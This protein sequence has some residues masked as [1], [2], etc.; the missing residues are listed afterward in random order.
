MNK[1]NM[2]VYEQVR[3]VPQSAQKE[4]KAG[5]LKGMTDINPMWRIKVLTETFGQVGVGW[6]A[7]IVSY[8]NDTIG[9]EIVTNMIINLYVKNGDEWSEPIVGIGG[10]KLATMESKGVYVSDEAYKM[11]YTD[12]ISVACKSLGVGADV[13]WA[14]DRSKYSATEDKA[15]VVTPVVISS[16]TYRQEVIALA[17]KLKIDLN[18]L[19]EMYNLSRETTEEQYKYVLEELRKAEGK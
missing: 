2:K 4:I 16:P 7:E 19:K 18:D 8:W 15:E 14:K 17:E 13:Y 12:A 1:D 9:S 11:A 5:R 3:S 6:K 10:S